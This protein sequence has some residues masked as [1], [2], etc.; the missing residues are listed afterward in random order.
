[1]AAVDH[2]DVTVED[3]RARNDIVDVISEFVRLKKAGRSFKGLCPFHKEKTP[4]FMVNAERQMF[5]CFGCGVGGD[6]FSFIMT[7]E[8]LEFLEALRYLAERAGMEP[9][10]AKSG[11]RP[12]ENEAIYGANRFAADFYHRHL[13]SPAG[14]QALSY[15]EKRGLVPEMIDLLRVGLAPEGRG[16][17]VKAAAGECL[18]AEL[19]AK[20]GLLGKGDRGEWY[21]R[22]RNRVMFPILDVVGHVVGLGGRLLGEGEPKYLNS[23][24]TRVFRKGAHLYGLNL[25]RGEIGREDR[26]L[27]VE[28]YLDLAALRQYGI[29][30]AVATM[31]TALAPEAARQLARY[32]QRVTV[33]ND[34]DEAGQK[35]AVRSA[36]VLLAQGFRVHVGVL[37]AGQ[38]PDSFVRSQGAEAFRRLVRDAPGIVG[39]LFRDAGDYEAQERATRVALGLFSQIEDPIRR[40]WYIKELAERAGLEESVLQKAASTRSGLPSRART[41]TPRRESPRGALQAEHG[42]IKYLLDAET[43]DT[44]VVDRIR[45]CEFRD[46]AGREVA[47]ALLEAMDRGERLSASEAVAAVESRAARTLVAAVSFRE[48]IVDEAKQVSD[49][50]AC[51]RRRELRERIAETKSEMR[52]AEQREDGDALRRLQSAYMSLVSE[53]K[54]SS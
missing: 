45:G 52:E 27:L 17:L 51:L 36:E 7:H 35:A 16:E 26:A 1:M 5:H 21:E 32:T 4:S 14:R 46:A 3:V 20:A 2:T 41:R 43:L 12:S 29:E 50:L 42:I 30:N 37:P 54:R 53:L 22:F 33:V 28:G 10:R 18:D 44:D 13:K 8:K 11:A 9:P 19:L 47:V 24:E 38:D 48:D 6:V 49:Y 31:G 40:T 34:G 39:Y 15:L 23:P 25:S